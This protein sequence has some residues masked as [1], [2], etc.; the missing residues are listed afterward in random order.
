[1]APRMIRVRA[2]DTSFPFT[3]TYLLF[4]LIYLY[5]YFYNKY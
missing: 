4:L 3:V 2:V 1:M 5:I